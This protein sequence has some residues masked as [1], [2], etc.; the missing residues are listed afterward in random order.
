MVAPTAEQFPQRQIR[1]PF[2]LMSHSATSIADNAIVKMPAGPALTAAARNLAATIS[3]RS[4]S[5]PIAS[6]PNSSTAWRRVRVSAPP[7]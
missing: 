2:P 4:G 3:T 6:A 5:S 7:K 1:A